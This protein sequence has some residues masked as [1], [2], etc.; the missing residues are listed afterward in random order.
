MNSRTNVLFTSLSPNC[1][2]CPSQDPSNARHTPQPA[3]SAQ[4]ATGGPAHL[5]ALLVHEPVVLLEHLLSPELEEVVWVRV[6]L[7]AVLAVL[8]ATRKCHI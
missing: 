4:S 7:H 2:I 3:T 6:E 1:A 8:P 5:F